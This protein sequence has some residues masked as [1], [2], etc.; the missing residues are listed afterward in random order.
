LQKAPQAFA[1]SNPQSS[2]SQGRGRGKLDRLAPATV[3][4]GGENR[5]A[6]EH[7]GLL[8]HLWAAG[9]GSG[10]AVAVAR[11]RPC[12]RWRRWAVGAAVRWSEAAWGRLGSFTGSQ[13]VQP[14]GL[15]GAGVTEVNGPRRAG[16]G[17]GRR[18]LGVVP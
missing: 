18:W 12:G 2:Q 8:A 9:I 15:G 17:G 16:G 4:A 6:G 11:R 5:G 10:Q 14:W 13:G 1:S 3:I 7:Q